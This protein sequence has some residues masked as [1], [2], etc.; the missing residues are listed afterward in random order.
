MST[1]SAEELVAKLTLEE[2]AQLCSG[3]GFWNLHG[4]ERLNLPSIM[5]TD[6]P[7]GLRK[8]TGGSDHVGL[9][10][11]VEATC[12]PTAS[13]L[14]ATW[15]S[16]LIHEMGVAL[17]KECRAE[18]VSVLLGPGLNIKRHPLG[19]RN[20]EYFSEDPYLSGVMSR[21]WI[22][23]VQS[24]NVGTSLK[25]FAV[26]NHEHC[27]MVVDAIVD[28][29]TLREIYFPG[30]E[31][32]V[33]E[34]QPWTVMCAYNKLNGT[35]LSEH[36]YMLTT[37]L[38]EEWGFEGLVV[39]DWGANNNRV[40]GLKAGQALEMPSSGTIGAKFILQA[41]E[42]G[43]L[44]T[45][46]LDRSVAK[47][48]RLIL[49]GQD[50]HY[51]D[52]ATD[53][54]AHHQ[55]AQRVATEACVLLKNENQLLPLPTNSTIAVLGELAVHTR[56]QGAGS[57]QIT[58]HQLETPLEE[59]QRVFGKDRVLY[60]EGYSR[61][62]PLT[63]T[64][65]DNALQ[66]AQAADH[67]VVV[68]GLTPEFESEGFDRQHM[69]LPP[70]Q[71]QLME[72]LTPVHHKLVVV[73]QNGAPVAL[74]FKAQVPAIL[75]AYLGGQAGASA[76]VQVLTGE[77]NPSGKLA[78][79]FPLHQSDVPS[80]DWYPGT[81]RQTQYREAIW[82][83]Y[84]Y[85]DTAEIPVA[86]P[87]GHGL[88]Y[89]TFAYSGLTISGEQTGTEPL[90]F[91]V[92]EG[93]EITV[94]LKVTNTGSIA[95]AEVVQLYI[96]ETD[97]SVP[98]PKKELKGFAK[99]D[100]Q[101]NETKSVSFALSQRDFAYWS[102]QKKSWVV[103]SG[104]FSVYAA[105]SVADVRLQETIHLQSETEAMNPE[106]RQRVDEAPGPLTEEAFV[107]WLGHPIPEPVPSLP[108]HTNSMLME[109]QQSWLGRR[110]IDII[111][112]VAKREMAGTINEANSK[113]LETMIL[114]MPI[115]NLVT[116][117]EGK[118][119]LPMLHRIIHTLNGDYGKVLLGAPPPSK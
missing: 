73:L 76:L 101:P 56:Y 92:K 65:I 44:T 107:N 41:I 96:G 86:F 82:V 17:G 104:S 105:A 55:L 71:L 118:L 49:K 112:A 14:A 42:Q 51:A 113:M 98:R 25:H 43:T 34:S 109:L 47:V 63:Q 30:F 37:L 91:S 94:E 85:F 79:T 58:P 97:P 3:K 99:V 81:T 50:A 69:N 19:G 52:E 7:H 95:G 12:F 1:M 60:S 64:Q 27:R 115:R 10:E 62:G 88:S 57:S 18:Q 2:K 31:I 59:F 119:S 6:G 75:E 23:G 5:V 90:S 45:E 77:V 78:E 36:H 74:P 102:M 68:L 38:E 8:Q 67:V 111:K 16:A 61:Q 22:R 110:L 116:M 28:E 35:Y 100:L 9:N 106:G 89:T 33:K 24:Q 117:S 46:E 54:E 11:S 84:R 83:G 72:A 70:Q 87:F 20:F 93:D 13:G 26:N 66:A 103:N 80:N 108:F 4:I 40:E 39:T 29:R 48:V 15:N 32:A 53:W 114:E 21:E